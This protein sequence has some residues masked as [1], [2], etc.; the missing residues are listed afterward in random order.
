MK[1]YYTLGINDWIMYACSGK[2]RKE[3]LS[4]LNRERFRN[5]CR[6]LWEAILNIIAWIIGAT[7]ILSMATRGLEDVSRFLI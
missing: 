3:K 7:I 1:G 4:R 5:Q 2:C 6:N